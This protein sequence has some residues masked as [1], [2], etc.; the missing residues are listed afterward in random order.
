MAALVLHDGAESTP[1]RF[2][3]FLAVQ[4]D[5]SP[6]ARPRHVRIA[7]PDL[8]VTATDKILERELVRQ[9]PTP[10]DGVLWT[11]QDRRTPGAGRGARTSPPTGRVAVSLNGTA[12]GVGRHHT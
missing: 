7:P 5:L 8:P 12:P 1:D 11:R 6:K 10:G 2:E 9:G 4:P 3:E